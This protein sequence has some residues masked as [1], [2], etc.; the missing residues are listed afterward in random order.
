MPKD[1]SG[2]PQCQ[3]IVPRSEGLATWAANS[4]PLCLADMSQ[5]F[6]DGGR[7]LGLGDLGAWGMGIPIGKLDSRMQSAGTRKGVSMEG[8]YLNIGLRIV[9]RLCYVGRAAAWNDRK[10]ERQES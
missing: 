3:C 9:L 10:Q 8:V 7:I 4:C 2:K 1:S 5:V 6:S